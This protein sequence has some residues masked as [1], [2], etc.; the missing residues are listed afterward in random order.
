[1][2]RIIEIPTKSL[3]RLTHYHYCL[4]RL[5]REKREY[6]SNERLAGDLNIPVNE[7]R[8][9]MENLD[10][11]LGV[12]EIHQT[13]FLMNIVEKYLGYNNKNSALIAGIGNLG[14]ALAGQ[15]GLRSFGVG[16]TALFDN[17][18]MQIGKHVASF[19]VYDIER[20][21]DMIRRLK[22]R[23]GVITTPPEA[24]G[25]IAGIMVDAGIEGIWNF[26]HAV[27]RVPSD[28]ALQNS[29]F[30]NDFINLTRQMERKNEHRKI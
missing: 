20:M 18:P 30:H 2:E 1:M 9:D 8:E 4:T 16:V 15:A 26:T 12:S 14:K 27:I 5:T 22:I 28:V 24:A 13:E 3:K 25:Q 11:A 7:V 6:V 29:S 17:D 19:E 21:A 23:I 10:P